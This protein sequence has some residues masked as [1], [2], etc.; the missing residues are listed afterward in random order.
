MLQL[1][2]VISITFADING[3]I[4]IRRTCQASKSNIPIRA[5]DGYCLSTSGKKTCYCASDRCNSASF[6]QLPFNFSEHMI[7][8]MLLH[9][10]MNDC[11]TWGLK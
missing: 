9:H 4:G 11:V 2:D 8:A 5:L 3:L 1:D 7:I 6:Y 10:I